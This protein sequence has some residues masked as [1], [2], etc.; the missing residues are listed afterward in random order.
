LERWRI[1]ERAAYL[2]R[3]GA[4]LLFHLLDIWHG[5]GLWERWQ[6]IPHTLG[7]PPSGAP[8]LTLG[9]PSS[10]WHLPLV[11][12]IQAFSPIVS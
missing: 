7:S 6:P 9:A 5:L 1:L 4:P 3:G 10:F 12:Y 11:L 8:L 2:L